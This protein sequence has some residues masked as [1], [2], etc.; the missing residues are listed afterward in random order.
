MA[1]WAHQKTPD[2]FTATIWSQSSSVTSGTCWLLAT[3][4]MLPKTSRRPWSATTCSTA[5]WQAA[6]SA[7]SQTIEPIDPAASAVPTRPASSMSRPTT[8]AP[9][10]ARRIAVARPM[11][12]AAPVRAATLPSNRAIGCLLARRGT[13]RR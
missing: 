3:P 4:A 5:A 11:P 13:G 7:T 12:E 2:T 8:V 6:R 9:S 1:A 10:A